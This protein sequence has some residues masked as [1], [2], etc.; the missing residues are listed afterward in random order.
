MSQDMTGKLLNKAAER[1]GL[2]TVENDLLRLEGE[3]LMVRVQELE[4]T[5]AELVQAKLAA[6]KPAPAEPPPAAPAKR[7]RGR[8][9]D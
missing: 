1:I 4:R 9:L 2:L 5:L 7:K 6:D 8:L 3:A